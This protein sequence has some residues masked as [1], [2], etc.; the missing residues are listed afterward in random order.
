MTRTPLAAVVLAAGLGTRMRSRRPKHFHPLLGRRLLDW[1]VD[2]VR[3][4][5]P[6]PLVVVVSPEAVAELED[7]LPAGAVLAVQEEP[8]GT[9][10]AAASARPA[11]E[12]FAGEVLV[13][14]GDTPLLSAGELDRLLHAHREESRAATVLSFEPD[15]PGNYGRILRDDAGR[16]TGIVEA[17]DA[18]PEELAVR[19]VNSS[20][21]VFAADALWSAL[22]RLDPHNAQGELYLTDAIRHLVDDAR[23][24]GVYRALD[25]RV[26]DGVNTRADLAAAAARL[27]DRIVAG[28][29]EAGVTIVDPGTT[30][31]EPDVEI[32]PDAVVHPFTV[33][34]GR[35]VVRR[36]AEV[37]PHAV[38]VDAEIGED[39]IV[40]PFCYLRPGTVLARN[41]KAGTFV[42]LKN[43]SLGE[44]AKVPHL[45]YLGD[46]DVGE[47]SNV[48]AGTITANFPHQEGRPKG[49][50]T[51]GRNVRTG[52]HNGLEAPVTIGD[53]AWIGGGSYITE[54]VPPQSLAIA[55][56]RQVTK[57]GYLRGKRND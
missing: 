22:D 24:V 34:R 20:V 23:G 53:D 27:R 4:L 39:A 33:L 40:G 35:T 49:R 41:A 8:R 32:E 21:Y 47:R 38:V 48:G 28:H 6:E 25:P 50:T 37:G 51:I 13:L 44:G 54:D 36:G 31:I 12:G 14:A 57:E 11:L 30:W 3:G 2:A 46:A 19:E 43:A 9:G 7:T 17:A 52:I 56:A 10:D 5:G 26:G 42:E 29:L 18:T 1:A 45:S 15:D 16:V 55:R